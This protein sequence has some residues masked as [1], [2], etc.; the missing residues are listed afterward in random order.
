MHILLHLYSQSVL[1]RKVSKYIRALRSSSQFGQPEWAP[2]RLLYPKRARRTFLGAGLAW[3]TARHTV[4]GYKRRPRAHSGWPVGTARPMAVRGIIEGVVISSTNNKVNWGSNKNEFRV[5]WDH[6]GGLEC[7]YYFNINSS[8]VGR[9]V[10]TWVRSTNHC[11]GCDLKKCDF[12][13]YSV[14]D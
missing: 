13:I 1:L 9:I 2:G 8:R 11:W 6:D 7:L 5:K 4:F 14:N 12:T 3:K 10:I